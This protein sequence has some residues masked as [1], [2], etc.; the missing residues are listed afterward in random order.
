MDELHQVG[1]VP[2]PLGVQDENPVKAHTGHV[3]GG[4]AVAVALHLPAH[5]GGELLPGPHPQRG[6]VH[7]GGVG[8]GPLEAHGVV[9]H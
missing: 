1:H 2:D 9:D 6:E 7:G 3:L 8:L 5:L 4:V